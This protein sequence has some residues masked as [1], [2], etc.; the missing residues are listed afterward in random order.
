MNGRRLFWILLPIL[1]LA[2]ALQA[3]HAE[4]RWRASRTVKAVQFLAAQASRGGPAAA[5]RLHRGLALMRGI[6]PFDPASV[7]IPVTQGG[8]Y[9]LLKRPQAAIRAYQEALR[10]EPRGEVYANLGR[11]YLMDG[12]QEPARKAFR[13]A[14]R[15]DRTWV[16]PFRPYLP[17]LQRKPAPSTPA[18]ASAPEPR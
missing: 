11:A 16:K 8:L 3:G 5:P 13:K 1:V 17:E 10:L 6:A 12:E 2:L 7:D 15:L 14:V 9:I 4:R 18:A